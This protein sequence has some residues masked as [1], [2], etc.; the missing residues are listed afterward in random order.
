MSEKR[1]PHGQP[2]SAKAPNGEYGGITLNFNIVKSFVL[3]RLRELAGQDLPLGGAPG[4][5]ERRL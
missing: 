3:M 5:P 4:N 2:P 1:R